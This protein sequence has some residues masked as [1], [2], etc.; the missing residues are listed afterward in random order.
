[1]TNPG[2]WAGTAAA[3]SCALLW[4]LYRGPRGIASHAVA[5]ISAALVAAAIGPGALVG[6]LQE[7]L[8]EAPLLALGRI[9]AGGLTGLFALRFQGSLAL[10]DAAP[11]GK[12]VPDRTRYAMLWLAVACAGLAAVAFPRAQGAPLLPLLLLAASFVAVALAESRDPPGSR[13]EGQG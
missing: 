4:A 13:S 1:M 6:G 3:A 7:V 9:V 8:S 11:G 5:F 12:L 2:L 10:P